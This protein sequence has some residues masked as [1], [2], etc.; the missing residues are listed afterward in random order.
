[1]SSTTHTSLS[2]TIIEKAGE[3][4]RRQG[5]AATTIKQIAKAVGCTNAALYYHFEGGKQHILHEVMRSMATEN[6]GTIMAEIPATN[7]ADLLQKLSHRISIVL[8]RITDRITWLLL[9]FP[10]LPETGK[11]FLRQQLL[12]IHN[13]FQGH[14]RP[15][16]PDDATA[17]RLAWVM[18]NAF[19]GYQQIFVKLDMQELV[20]FSPADYGTF[21]ASALKPSE[22]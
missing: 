5:Y 1:M 18:Y 7:L 13:I 4:F 11:S 10:T 19:I 3:L 9:D 12:T 8:P 16:V 17:D 15:F 14:I 22:A 6:I 2:D 20:D 21:L